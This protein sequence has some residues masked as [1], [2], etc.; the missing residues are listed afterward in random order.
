MGLPPLIPASFLSLWLAA[1]G[2]DVVQ[3][4]LVGVAGNGASW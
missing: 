3:E 1:C 2:D 4:L